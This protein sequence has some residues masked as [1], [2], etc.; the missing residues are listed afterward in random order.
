MAISVCGITGDPAEFILERSRVAVRAA[1]T[2]GAGGERFIRLN[3]GTRQAMSAEVLSL[4]PRSL[5]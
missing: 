1:P 2:F 5:P 4:I 3:L